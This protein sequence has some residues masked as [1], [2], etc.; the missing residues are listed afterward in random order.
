[1]IRLYAAGRISEDD[2]RGEKVH[3]KEG[4]LKDPQTGLDLVSLGNQMMYIGPWFCPFGK[5]GGDVFGYVPN[6]HAATL[7]GWPGGHRWTQFEESLFHEYNEEKPAEQRMEEARYSVVAQCLLQIEASNLVYARIEPEAYGT[8]VEIGYAFNL[9]KPIFIEFDGFDE[10]SSCWDMRDLW[11]A[12]KLSEMSFQ[13]LQND[14]LLKLYLHRIP[15][16]KKRPMNLDK[17]LNRLVEQT[18]DMR[19]ITGEY[20]D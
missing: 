7:A 3:F 4:L 14:K 13:A 17:Y 20:D 9:R 5:H 12:A 11:F 16:W 19:L 15:F 18:K 8:L 2:W 6:S 10:G 1:M